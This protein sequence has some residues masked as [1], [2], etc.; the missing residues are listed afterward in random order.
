VDLFVRDDPADP[1]GRH[2]SAARHRPHGLV[3]ADLAHPHWHL[4][5]ALLGV[6]ER[7]ARPEPV[8]SR[9]FGGTDLTPRSISP[10]ESV[11]KCTTP[12]WCVML[13]WCLRISLQARAI[14][15]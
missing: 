4:S 11:D 8:R 10:R 14:P 6:C 13:I 12:A 1:C 3:D 9:S 5:A 7:H 15:F 2:S